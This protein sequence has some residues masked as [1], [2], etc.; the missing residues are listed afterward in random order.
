MALLTRYVLE[1][2]LRWG[3]GEVMQSL[4]YRLLYKHHLRCS[5]KC[6]HHISDL[7]MMAYPEKK[8]KP[9]Y[10]NRVRGIWR[11]EKGRLKR[12]LVR[13]SLREF[14]SILTDPNGKY[15]YKIKSLPRWVSYRLF[16]RKVLPY[17]R[18]LSYLLNHA[19]KNS[20]IEA[21]LFAYPELKLKPY[22]FAS[23]PNRYWSG[24]KGREHALEAINELVQVLTNPEG[25]FNF[26]LE[27][28]FQKVKYTTYHKRH[29]LPHGANLS[30]MLHV[31]FKNSP[32]APLKF[33]LEQQRLKQASQVLVKRT[34]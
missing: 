33:L 1:E 24:E 22:H 32:T 30:G 31:L 9:Y 3:I 5:K 13:E 23:V 11:E 15:R 34:Q 17:G 27:E 25:Q 18:N 8:L 19:F 21:I 4:S 2:K 14:I 10:F 16:Q 28:L 29:I 20:P 7:V 12:D 26:T 6:F